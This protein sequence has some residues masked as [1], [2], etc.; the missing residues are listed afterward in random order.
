MKIANP[1]FFPLEDIKIIIKKKKK[2]YLFGEIQAEGKG[3]PILESIV[4]EEFTP[5]PPC[6][7]V[8]F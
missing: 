8:M 4:P 2:G 1:T 5:V 6:L 3:Q 7:K